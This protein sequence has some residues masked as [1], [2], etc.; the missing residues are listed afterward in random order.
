MSSSDDLPESEVDFNS[1]KNYGI[2]A[3]LVRP[4]EWYKQEYKDCK[5]ISILNIFDFHLLI[6]LFFN[7]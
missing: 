4:C 5:C 1:D 7:V 3:W 2:N 6:H